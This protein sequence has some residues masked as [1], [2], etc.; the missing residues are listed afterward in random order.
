MLSSAFLMK[1]KNVSVQEPG[2]N[3]HMSLAGSKDNELSVLH[4]TDFCLPELSFLNR[5]R[6]LVTLAVLHYQI[7]DMVCFTICFSFSNALTTRA[8]ISW[9][10][11]NGMFL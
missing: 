2:V 7:F 8:S 4:S 1:I 5:D 10:G 9:L 11:W 3:W 6:Y